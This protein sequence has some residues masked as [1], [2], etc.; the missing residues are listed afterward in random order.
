MLILYY[1]SKERGALMELLLYN[2]LSKQHT[3]NTQT[4]TLV[5][6]YRKH[7]IPFIL[8]N[9][10]R[11][12]DIKKYLAYKTHIKKIIILG[13]DGTINHF[14]NNMVHA[15]DTTPEIYIKS[16]G[17]G[18]DFLRTLKHNDTN[19]QYIM[20]NTFDNGEIKYF[21]NGTGMGL[22]GYVIHRIHQSEKKGKWRYMLHTLQALMEYVPDTLMV[23]ID[24]IPYEFHNTYFITL[25]NGKF[26][27]GGMK[28]S[29][30]ATLDDEYLDIIIVHSINKWLLLPVFFSIYFGLHTTL[31]KYVFHTKGKHITAH[32]SKPNISQS[33]GEM[34]TGV[35]SINVRSSG[36]TIHLKYFDA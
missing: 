27:G 24:G 25:N 29:P 6:Y 23:N 10:I 4:Y 7:N 9:I 16:N 22:D 17:T 36:K 13:G 14:I 15:I 11:I 34:I 28:I 2:P 20:Q 21:I 3:S 35:T 32:Y 26:F 30:D 19:P 1:N 5:R 31:K 12:P 33:D 18:N 8:K